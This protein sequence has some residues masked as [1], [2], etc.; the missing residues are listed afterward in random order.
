MPALM[1]WAAGQWRSMLRMELS[2]L[3][4]TEL[5]R[6]WRCPPSQAQRNCRRRQFEAGDCCQ[7]LWKMGLQTIWQER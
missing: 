7:S 5:K 6:D 3:H 1:I 4:S 2:R